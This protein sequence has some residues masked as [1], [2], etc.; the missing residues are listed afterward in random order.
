M[1]T[2]LPLRS[3]ALGSATFSPQISHLTLW[4]IFASSG[5]EILMRLIL[6]SSSSS[7]SR[8]AFSFFAFLEWTALRTSSERS[9]S[10]YLF[11]RAFSS[12][13]SSGG[14]KSMDILIASPEGL[15]ANV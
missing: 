9:P 8:I 2:I 11:Q 5:K 12:S 13:D 4:Y 6:R 3:L 10:E 15:F 1:Q 14:L 7:A